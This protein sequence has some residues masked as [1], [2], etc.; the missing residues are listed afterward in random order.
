METTLL[1]TA[2]IATI[3]ARAAAQAADYNVIPTDRAYL[4]TFYKVAHKSDA[5]RAYTVDNFAQ[6]CTC[7]AFEK[8]GYCKH[9]AMYQAFR[10]EDAEREAREDAAELIRWNRAEDA[11]GFRF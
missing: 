10:R 1:P 7:T 6:T 2:R 4:D 3:R 11:A 5:S 8:E 9:Y